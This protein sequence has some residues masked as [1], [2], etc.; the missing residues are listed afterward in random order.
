MDLV[1]DMFIFPELNILAELVDI[2][3]WHMVSCVVVL[4]EI[5]DFEN[6]NPDVLYFSDLNVLLVQFVS[7]QTVVETLP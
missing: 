1:S 4:E 3:L 6:G 2:V 7:R 5:A